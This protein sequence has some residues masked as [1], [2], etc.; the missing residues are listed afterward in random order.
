MG[1]LEPEKVK[2]AL[3]IKLEAGQIINYGIEIICLVYYPIFAKKET[4]GKEVEQAFPNSRKRKEP[5]N[6]N[7]L[8]TE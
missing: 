8:E 6:P 7:Y 2:Q 3:Y 4:S 5:F 1:T